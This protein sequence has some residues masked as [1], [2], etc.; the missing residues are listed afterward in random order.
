[1]FKNTIIWGC[2]LLL[3]SSNALAQSNQSIA[4]RATEQAINVAESSGSLNSIYDFSPSVLLREARWLSQAKKGQLQDRAIKY[5]VAKTEKNIIEPFLSKFKR[6]EF[7]LRVG[8]GKPIFEILTVQPLH[9]STDLADTFFTQLSANG[10]DGRT[11][12]NLGLGYRK[13]AYD[14]KL[15]LGINGFYDHE[16]P[17][18]HQ[19]TSIGLELRSTAF[20]FN[21]NRYFAV[22]KYKRDKN[23]VQA[24]SLGGHDAEIGMM[25][26]YLP[27]MRA[28]VRTFSWYGVDGRP[29]MN[30]YEYSLRGMLSPE[31]TVE[32][33]K[34]NY[35]S[36]FLKDQ[37]T[38]LFT[39]RFLSQKQK[40]AFEKTPFVMSQPYRMGTMEAHRLDKV[41]RENRIIKQTKFSINAAGF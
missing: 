37:N 8:G 33:K 7:S 4:L 6:T 15:L 41:R 27:R 1:M 30:G 29:N 24:R 38:L 19:R 3:I 16:F 35:A 26:P 28:F 22:S 10:Y 25:L 14:N 17:Y 31:F 32:I 11:T 21:I 34:T 5:G 13:L 20:E 9:E 12:V 39:Y 36:N 23:G 40:R 18:D 2:L